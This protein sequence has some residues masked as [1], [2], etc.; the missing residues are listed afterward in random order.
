LRD[1]QPGEFYAFGP[2]LTRTVTRLKIGGVLSTHPKVGDRLAIKTPAPSQ[3][4]LAILQALGDLPREA[5]TEALTLD[6]LRAENADLKQ[7]LAAAR[8]SPQGVCEAEVKARV[9]A[10]VEAAA[11]AY[12]RQLREIVRLAE[13]GLTAKQERPRPALAQPVK[14]S[15]PA[16]PSSPLPQ[17]DITQPQQRILDAM[18][19]LEA[20]GLTALHKTQVAVL[21]GVSPNSG[22]FANNLGRLRSLGLI[23]YPQSGTVAFTEAGQRR[24]RSV[25]TPPTLSDLHQVW[26]E[27][28][29]GPQA[30]ILR[31]VMST[32]PQAIAKEDLAKCIAVS[33]ESGSYANNLGR[34]RTLGVIEYPKRGYVR[35]KDVLFPVAAGG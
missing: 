23:D 27:I 21:A 29:T 11:Q 7:R 22:S 18:A 14:P 24:A 30:R 17:G 15:V 33:P 6:E 9:A 2:A 12:Q 32:Y 4:V 1:L 5:K 28:V 25:T 20:L 10:A 3:K 34:L 19:R 13:Q 31:E 35:A 8:K 26:L 16:Q